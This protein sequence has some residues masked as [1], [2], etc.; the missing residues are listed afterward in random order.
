M[1][2][3]GTSMG[4][5]APKDVSWSLRRGH[6]PSAVLN[7]CPLFCSNTPVFASPIRWTVVRKTPHVLQGTASAVGSV[8]GGGGL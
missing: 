4:H 8:G 7:V 1:F 5:N 2:R 3:Y 6:T